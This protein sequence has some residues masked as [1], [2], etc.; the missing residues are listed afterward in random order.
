MDNEIRLEAIGDI[1]KLPP[2]VTEPLHALR[3][4]RTATVA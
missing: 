4:T 1:D 2:S 3:A